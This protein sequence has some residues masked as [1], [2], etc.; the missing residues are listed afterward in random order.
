MFQRTVAMITV[1]LATITGFAAVSGSTA[2]AAAIPQHPMTPVRAIAFVQA[3][4]SAA[5][6]LAALDALSPSDRQYVITY[7]LTPRKLVVTES[8]GLSTMVT[9]PQ[10]QVLASAA[11]CGSWKHDFTAKSYSWLGLW[12]V[13]LP[14]AMAMVGMRWKD[15]GGQPSGTRRHCD[16][17]EL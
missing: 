13:H 4:H 5:A 16:R 15:H 7:A 8:S 3:H 14:L 17:L 2:Y 9:T 12:A 11:S 6:M 1:L 10:S